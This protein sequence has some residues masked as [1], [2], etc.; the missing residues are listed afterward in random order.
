MKTVILQPAFC[1]LLISHMLCSDPQLLEKEDHTR[2]DFVDIPQGH[3]LRVDIERATGLRFET[4]RIHCFQP[5]D[6]AREHVDNI[7]PGTDT[8]IARLDG[9]GPSR[10][11]VN[12]ELRYEQ[13]GVGYVLPEGTAHEIITGDEPRYTLVGW[14]IR[15]VSLVA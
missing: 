5:H 10:L 14:A 8:M 4:L 9:Y 3:A 15:P 1:G 11:K 12:G 7:H 13:I 2:F 6:K